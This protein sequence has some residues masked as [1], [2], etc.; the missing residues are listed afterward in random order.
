MPTGGVTLRA[1][2]MERL[3]NAKI[4]PDLLDLAGMKLHLDCV[5]LAFIDL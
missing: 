5:G 3:F 4:I 2:L 1:E